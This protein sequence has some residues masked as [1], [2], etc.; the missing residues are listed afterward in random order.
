MEFQY[1]YP[2]G[3]DMTQ[4]QKDYIRSYMDRFEDALFSDDFRNDQGEHYSQLIDIET[5]ADFLLINELSKNSDGYKLS[6]YL[7]KDND[8]I[9][10]RLKIGPIWDFDQTYGMSIICSNNN[11]SG[12]TYL[13]TQDRC[14]DLNTMPL[15]WDHLTKDAAFCDLLIQKWNTYR[16]SFLHTDSIHTWIDEKA[17]E[18]EQARMRNFSTWWIIGAQV[19]DE[20]EPIKQTYEEE[21]EYMKEWIQK[22]AEWIDRNIYNIHDLAT[23]KNFV[24]IYPNPATD[25]ANITIL[26]GS[27]VKVCDLYGRQLW[28]SGALNETNFEL[29][30][31]AWRPGYYLV[32][33]YTERGVFSGKLIVR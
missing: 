18:I 27:K 21:V 3:D 1:Y 20:P 19:W 13:Q 9:D 25:I 22:R 2:K 6:T 15:W 7:H 4:S 14:E 33:V 29:N 32:Y 12:W 23:A 31:A 16:N 5:F 10:G 24:K 8:A 30:T 17:I 11:Y 26:P 28:E